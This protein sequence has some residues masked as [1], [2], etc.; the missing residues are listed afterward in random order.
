MSEELAI[1]RGTSL[2]KS[3]TPPIGPPKSLL[4]ERPSCRRLGGVRIESGGLRIESGV[5]WMES[6]ALMIE[7]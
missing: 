5:P 6:E 1:C 7:F 4:V 2:V 3:R